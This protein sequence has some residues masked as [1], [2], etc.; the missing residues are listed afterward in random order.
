MG[1][2][3]LWRSMLCI[4]RRC[5][6]LSTRLARIFGLWSFAILT[7]PEMR[8]FRGLLGKGACWKVKQTDS[9]YRRVLLLVA[10]LI[11]VVPGR[12][13]AVLTLDQPEEITVPGPNNSG[14]QVTG[15]TKVN[16]HGGSGYGQFAWTLYY[17]QTP[18]GSVVN[19]ILSVETTQEK[20]QGAAQCSTHQNAYFSPF[21]QGV[22][23]SGVFDIR[24]RIWQYFK[25]WGT[26]KFRMEYS[27]GP[28][29]MVYREV[30]IPFNPQTIPVPGDDSNPGVLEVSVYNGNVNPAVLLSGATVWAGG[31]QKTTGTSGKSVFFGYTQPAVISVSVSG[32]GWPMIKA[33]ANVAPG[34]TTKVKVVLRSDTAGYAEVVNPP[35]PGASTGGGGSGGGGSGSDMGSML[36]QEWWGNI[37]SYLFVPSTGTLTAWGT[38]IDTV[39]A[40]GPFGFFNSLYAVWTVATRSLGEN[41][42]P[43]SGPVFSTTIQLFGAGS[44]GGALVLDMRPTLAGGAVYTAGGSG[45]VWGNFAQTMRPVWGV[46][47]WGLFIWGVYHWIRPRLS[48]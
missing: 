13:W 33:T 9:I 8:I 38:F 37:F 22:G 26:Y 35:P 36:S 27:D 1:A 44:G 20:Y 21:V 17:Y 48:T 41:S 32:N 18:S 19:E 47:V 15:W 39:K 2:L 24:G 23:E 11:L 10:L 25:D 34:Y 42:G 16:G 6:P 30:I 4:G 46:V 29:T 31:F 3:V 5:D 12:A 14:D 40:W 43:E 7:L 28:G 45:S